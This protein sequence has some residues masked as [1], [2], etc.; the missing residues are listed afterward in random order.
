[1]FGKRK[2]AFVTRSPGPIG[3]A[4]AIRMLESTMSEQSEAF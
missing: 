1:M 4:I 2:I 3:Q